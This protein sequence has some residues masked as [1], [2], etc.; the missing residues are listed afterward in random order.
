MVLVWVRLADKLVYL[1]CVFILVEMSKHIG[2][3]NTSKAIILIMSKNLQILMVRLDQQLV[4][5]IIAVLFA[6]NSFPESNVSQAEKAVGVIANYLLKNEYKFF[7]GI[8][9]SA[10][11]KE[12]FALQA[13]LVYGCFGSTL[14]CLINPIK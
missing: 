14:A 4:L 13:M 6:F 12:K 9:N 5:L 11:F 7:L 2:N 8:L 3:T 10:N 1:L